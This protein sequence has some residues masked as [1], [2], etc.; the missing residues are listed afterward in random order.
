MNYRYKSPLSISLHN[1]KRAGSLPRS[2]SV[3]ST[4]HCKTLPNT[5]LGLS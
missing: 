4:G 1:E 5:V 2:A 3:K